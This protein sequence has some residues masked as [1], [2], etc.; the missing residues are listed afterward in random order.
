ML[1]VSPCRLAAEYDRQGSRLP[2]WQL[3]P[4]LQAQAYLNRNALYTNISR[5]P[6]LITIRRIP[7]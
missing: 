6:I 3:T 2:A 4:Q 1:D 5:Q 7:P